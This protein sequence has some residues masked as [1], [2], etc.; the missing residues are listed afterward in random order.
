[1]AH[2]A[3][4]GF[5]IVTL[6]GVFQPVLALTLNCNGAIY[7]TDKYTCYNNVQLCPVING[8][9]T[10]SCGSACYSEHVYR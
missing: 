5:V 4:L 3:Y 1:M 9:P 7:D 10:L 6:F 2:L 8:A